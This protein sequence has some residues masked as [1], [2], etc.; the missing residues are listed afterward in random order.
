MIL[1]PY[2][3]LTQ[4]TIN[5]GE[6]VTVFYYECTLICVINNPSPSSIYSW[7]LGGGTPVIGTNVEIEL[8]FDNTGS[9]TLLV[10]YFANGTTT[11]LCDSD[12]FIP[13]CG[14]C[15]HV[16]PA[17]DVNYGEVTFFMVP[18]FTQ[19][20][21]WNFGD[22]T[23]ISGLPNTA[24]TGSQNTWG[25]YENPTHS[26]SQSGTYTVTVTST[27]DY[28]SCTFTVTVQ[29]FNLTQVS[30]CSKLIYALTPPT[31]LLT[32]TTQ[33]TINW[34]DGSVPQS[35]VGLGP[36][37]H[38]Y[39][40][41]NTYNNTSVT[42]THDI[43]SG[44]NAGQ[45]ATLVF[46]FPPQGIY[47]GQDGANT[48]LADLISSSVLPANS[49]TMIGNANNVFVNGNLQVRQNYT[50]SNCDFFFGNNA[51]ISP[52]RHASDSPVTVAFFG[53]DMDAACTQLWFGINVQNFSANAAPSLTL[54]NCNVNRAYRAISLQSNMT[55]TLNNNTF[56]N[57]Y[58]GIF[59]TGI[60]TGTTT[61]CQPPSVITVGAF[62]NNHFICTGALLPTNNMI[63]AGT[64]RSLAGIQLNDV[65]MFQIQSQTGTNTFQGMNSGILVWRTTLVISNASFSNL[66]SEVLPLN[67]SSPN[68]SLGWAIRSINTC[69]NAAHSLT[70]VGLGSNLNNP[71]SIANCDFGIYANGVSAS[72]S[73]NRIDNVIEG[74]KVYNVNQ[75]GSA[76][77]I[78]NRIQAANDCIHYNSMATPFAFI[79]NNVLTT[80]GIAP[81][82]PNSAPSVAA[83]KCMNCDIP[84]GLNDTHIGSNEITVNG[85]AFGI[86]TDNN[87]E[88]NIRNNFPITLG[89]IDV[90][91]SGI[92]SEQCQ[93]CEIACNNV[94]RAALDITNTNIG[95]DYFG[96][97]GTMVSCNRFQNLVFGFRSHFESQNT[98]LRGN[99][100]SNDKFGIQNGGNGVIGT[101]THTGNFWTGADI[102]YR[103]RN[104]NTTAGAILL[105]YDPTDG[106]QFD[107]TPFTTFG[108]I[109][110]AQLDI[111]PGFNTFI[112]SPLT[113]TFPSIPVFE[114][115]VAESEEITT[116]FDGLDLLIAEGTPITAEFTD[117]ILWT[118][119]QKLYRRL[120]EQPDLLAENET[121]AAFYED[122]GEDI[123]K[124]YD[125][126]A[127]K[128]S[129]RK[130]GNTLYQDW[131]SL[132]TAIQNAMNQL[133]ALDTALLG[134]PT[135]VAYLLA[136][137]EQVLM[138]IDSL[139]GLQGSILSVILP[140]RQAL[141]SEAVL[142]T[143]DLDEISDPQL[144][145][146]LFNQVFLERVGNPTAD[147]TTPQILT[148]E[149]IADQ[150]PAS[151]GRAVF[152]ARALLAQVAHRSYN[153]EATCEAAGIAW[154]K[155]Q[156][157]NSINGERI[158]DKRT[159]APS[160]APSRLFAASP[161]PTDGLI[162][163]HFPTC[164][165][166]S[167]L[168]LRNGLGQEVAKWDIMPSQ[169]SLMT[170]VGSVGSGVYY[171]VFSEYG[172]PTV[173]QKVIIIH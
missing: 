60:N 37:P 53:C 146:K 13:G 152:A 81:I 118:A 119:G 155:K 35:V 99:H 43:T 94:T 115:C 40:N 145:E 141:C 108:G 24:I 17:Y 74:I 51:S 55:L 82:P 147:F 158:N 170:N 88:L 107:P 92:R 52:R 149:A 77:V 8:P 85:N 156:K 59:R 68:G 27:K 25:T 120:T 66:H 100:F 104:Y 19:P 173:S 131:N 32:A 150:C 105:F 14:A 113:T 64:T 65:S 79:L 169:Q 144:F 45:T 97:T 16:Q 87:S 30:D 6:A 61:L 78:N 10:T 28:S 73:N 160:D 91:A 69:T 162:T 54:N 116:G 86:F 129:I 12:F 56:A 121:L 3:A 62:N 44:P 98:V 48:I 75:F 154:L 157:Q 134:S 96:N 11:T 84:Q 58:L 83:I 9:Y 135:N 26:Y 165:Q 20:L 168:S 42:V 172:K 90:H 41:V 106:P 114:S 7:T 71:P 33:S 164:N 137:K 151:G 76:S 39:T 109:V 143:D 93:N 166:V 140:Q 34:G 125:V 142:K 5:C 95:L 1:S 124:F 63:V 23:L 132:E 89:N 102:F 123:G 136:Q 138:G 49:L 103:L 67:A 153:D 171:A 22:N 161:T 127:L 2:R 4:G 101:Q 128:E 112:C 36:F 133:V 126:E 167:V 111:T 21:I 38:T 117:E 148:L 47:I 80:N 57:N 72:I 46:T 130:L 70:Q 110:P 15:G 29:L 139:K 122:R 163:F 18:D 31:G 159:A 50:F